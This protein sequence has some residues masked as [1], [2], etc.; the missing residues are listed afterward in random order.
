[1]KSTRRNHEAA[2]KASVAVG[3]LKG[4]KTLPELAELFG[5][6]PTSPAL[7]MNTS[8]AIADVQARGTGPKARGKDFQSKARLFPLATSLAPMAW[9]VCTLS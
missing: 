2:F 6:H 5:V 9:P 1:M 8:A 3:A 4:D 7:F